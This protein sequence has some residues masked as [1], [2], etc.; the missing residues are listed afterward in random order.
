[1]RRR[2]VAILLST[3]LLGFAGAGCGAITAPSLVMKGA[4]WAAGE[5]VKKE[6][7]HLTKDKHTASS[8]PASER[9]SEH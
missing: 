3:S 8:R 4:Q 5:V 1:M 9:H 6:F 7:K 2:I